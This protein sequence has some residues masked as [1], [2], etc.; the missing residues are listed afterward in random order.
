MASY[1]KSKHDLG[2]I[3]TDGTTKVGLR[4]AK[5][6]KG[7]PIYR[8]YDDEYLAQQLFTGTPGY[9]NLPPEKELAI[10]QDDWRSGFGQETY[11][12]N[13]PKRYYSSIGMD[14]RYKGMAVAGPVSTAATIPVHTA[15]AYNQ[16]IHYTDPDTAWTNEANAIDG[17]VATKAVNAF[18]GT[19]K[20][21]YIYVPAISCSKVRYYWTEAVNN[22][23]T[24]LE[25]G[26]YY[27][28]AWHVVVSDDS[29]GEGALAEAALAST[30]TVTA[31]RVKF[32]QSANIA[33]LHVLEFYAESA[34]IQAHPT[35]FADFNDY[36][37][38]GAGNSLWKVDKTSGAIT[39]ILAF[40]VDITD[41]EPFT[42]NRLYIAL[43]I[44][45]TYWYIDTSDAAVE[46]T[47]TP[48]KFQFFQR[49]DAAAP[50]M[51][52]NNTVSIIYSSTHPSNGGANWAGALGVD[53]SYHS[54]TDLISK[55]G[56]LY[57]M[58]EDM[59]YYLSSTPA[60]QND[61]APELRSATAST[62]GK[63]AFLWKN[64]LYIPFG[65]QGLLETDGTTN[66]F[67][68][69]ASYCTNLSDFV[70]R[71]MAV[72]GDEEYLF[73][74][75]DNSTEIEILAGRE[76]TIDGTTGWVWHPIHDLT[77]TGCE[78][79][80]VSSV[81]QK[82][83]WI[84][85]DTVGE[86]LYYIPLPTGY[87]DII[88]DTNRS[89]K[90]GSYMITPWLHGNF[91]SDSKGFIKITLTMSGTTSTV[92]FTVEY[93]LKGSTNW[94]EINPT[95][96]FKTSPTTTGYIPVDDVSSANPVSNMIRF[97]ITAVTG[98]TTTT[99]IL[100]DYDCRAILYPTN[101]RIIEC[102]VLC[103]DEITLKDGT[104]EKGQAA[105]IKTALEEA[106]NAT[107]PATFYEIGE[108]TVYVKFLPLQTAVTKKEKG[109]G[110]ERHY[111]LRLQEVALS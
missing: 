63:N 1:L 11:D 48:D 109:R 13:D 52:G 100:Y 17:S 35:C 9:G 14:M 38:I 59:P 64:K 82:R 41:I 4:L 98:A 62:S 40:L 21:L 69:P 6:A 79:I 25:I 92:Y 89:F 22:D 47:E 29:Q 20:Y 2:F 7:N 68:N 94:T 97:K 18:A 19:Q 99:P 107:W 31:A 103:D 74:A 60:V 65:A 50:T 49:V 96:K 55:S 8:T 71:V 66:T 27:G 72:A 34:V 61:L 84:A 93:Q 36:L 43:G 46:S 10:R 51:W 58:K 57:I 28:G 80:Y 106:R 39:A 53:S 101:R 54:I 3:R 110:I 75:V 87:G 37:Y 44:S 70:G 83:L 5:D 23:V 90:T 12:A 15:S 81:K 91:K 95:A 33:Y 24:D 86:G 30:Q 85:S 26:V 42:D 76:E 45:N 77:L 16:A 32:T 104:I 105:T 111:L 88:N 102:E 108:S 67:L 56:S 73:V 78:T